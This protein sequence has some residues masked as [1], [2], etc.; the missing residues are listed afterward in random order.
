[1][2]ARAESSR[3]TEAKIFD[4][5]EELFRTKLFA[6]VTLQALAD[7]AGV[8]LQTVLRRFGSKDKLFVA[9]AT[10]LRERT[11]TRRKPPRLAEPAVAVRTLVASYEE[12][13]DIGWQLLVQES[14]DPLLGR[15]LDDARASHRAWVEA[16][17]ADAL[18]REKRERARRVDLLFCATDFYQWKLLRRDLGKSRAETARRI[19]EA[20]DA[21]LRSFGGA[22]RGRR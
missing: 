7:R 16:V 2:V 9:A 17:F 21:L 1:M 10:R 11:M 5:A 22:D 19:T 8:T 6:Q 18:P 14:L 15:F 4:A 12:M 3:R 13:G 20:V